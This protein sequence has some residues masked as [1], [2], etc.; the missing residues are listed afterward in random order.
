MKNLKEIL[1][2]KILKE[3]NFY[4]TAFGY[5]IKIKIS[6]SSLKLR[7]PRERN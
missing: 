7:V 3:R 6:A 2:K 4:L 5:T 1:A